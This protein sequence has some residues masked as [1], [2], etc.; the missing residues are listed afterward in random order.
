MASLPVEPMLIAGVL[1]GLSAGVIATDVWALTR[2]GDESSRVTAA[3]LIA[4]LASICF[5]GGALVEWQWL[6]TVLAIVMGC[7]GAVA[8]ASSAESAIGS[9]SIEAA[10]LREAT[11]LPDEDLARS[12]LPGDRWLLV[13]GMTGAGKTTLVDAMVAAA[14]TFGGQ[15]EVALT[16]PVQRRESDGFP[17]TQLSFAR[18]GDDEHRVRIW[19]CHPSDDG[20]GLPP[21]AEID[22]I[23]LVV[24]P[25]GISGTARSFPAGVQTP[26]H[27]VDVDAMI[28][29]L[30]EELRER[31]NHPLVWLAITKADLIPFSVDPD[32]LRFPVQ[33]G[34]AWHDQLRSLDVLARIDLAK[35]LG[36]RQID[37]SAQSAFQWGTGTPYLTFSTGHA[38]G[39]ERSFGAERLMRQIVDS[40][41]RHQGER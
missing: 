9:E 5:L 40:V 36:I 16:G 34:S 8:L 29:Q 7:T 21:P 15:Q 38:E 23:I 13:V 18:H 14:K 32:L 41:T 27:D 12:K 31:G 17:V 28:L 22:A 19:E 37:S 10:R 35:R 24:D 11:Q 3:A 2:S 33:L 25:T 39:H 6:T 4:V 1:L 30:S 20:A 26:E